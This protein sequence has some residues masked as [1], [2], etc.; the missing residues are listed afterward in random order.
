MIGNGKKL[1][2][3]L[4]SFGGS[5][6]Y[7]SQLTVYCGDC[8]GC[9]GFGLNCVGGND[10]VSETCGLK[11]EVEFDTVN[12]LTYL[13]Q[14][15]GAL[16]AGD[17]TLAVTDTGIPSPPGTV[18]G[19]FSPVTSCKRIGYDIEPNPCP[20]PFDPSTN[21]VSNIDELACVAYLGYKDIELC[22]ESSIDFSSSSNIGK[23]IVLPPEAKIECIGTQ[24]KE[25]ECELVRPGGSI[26]DGPCAFFETDVGTEDDKGD[27]K[28]YL[29]GIKL[30]TDTDGDKIGDFAAAT[31]VIDY[32]VYE[33]TQDALDIKL[34]ARTKGSKSCKADSRRDLQEVQDETSSGRRHRSPPC[35]LF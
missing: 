21:C 15:H 13:I 5:A 19:D 30:L 32:S 24:E 20:G 8:E 11:S 35:T 28:L 27:G 9:S 14:V 18:C 4:C 10:D 31:N 17:F 2:A 6:N 23:T 22:S 34:K 7:D 33:P 12:G 25:C 29:K 1:V 16:D 26:L 3:S